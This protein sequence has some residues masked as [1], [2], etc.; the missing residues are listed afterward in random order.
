[1][2]F[3]N[4]AARHPDAFVWYRASLKLEKGRTYQITVRALADAPGLAA[5][6]PQLFSTCTDSPT[7]QRIFRWMDF[8]PLIMLVP[9]TLAF[10]AALMARR[11][12]EKL[13]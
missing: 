9:M 11:E 13:G 6:Q 2:A 7:F 4:S 12:R 10:G 1:M 3:L 5:A 8:A